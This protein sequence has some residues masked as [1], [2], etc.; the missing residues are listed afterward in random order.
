MKLYFRKITIL[1][2]TL[3][4][5]ETTFAG[6]QNDS[7]QIR[8]DKL[9]LIQNIDSLLN[10]R[11]ELIKYVE[12]SD[13][14]LFLELANKNLELAKKENI[15]WSQI[16]TYMEL[17][18]SFI[19][20]G[21]YGVALNYLNQALKL[22]QN[23]EYR[24]YVGWVT[25]SIGNCYEAMSSFKRA[26]EFF[27]LSMKVFIETEAT[28]GI[29]LAAT[30]IGNIYIVLRDFTNARKY[31]DKGFEERVK[32]K[33]PIELGYVR[34]SLA[35][36][37]MTTG[38]FVL[39]KESLHKLIQNL[40]D[41]V[42]SRDSGINVILAKD[43][44]GEAL[45]LLSEC[46]DS[47]GLVRLKYEHLFRA[48][49]LFHEMDD[50]LN[51]STVFNI[52]GRNYLIDHQFEEA[53]IY[54]DSARQTARDKLILIQQAVSD[55][56][57]S[58]IYVELKD[59][60]QALKYH[61]EYMQINDSMYNQSV[62][63]AI[64]NVDVFVET[65]TKEKNNQILVLEVAHEKKIRSIILIYLG[66][67]AFLLM[68]VITYVFNRYRKGKQVN[69][70][71]VVKNKQIQDQ[72]KRL[73][74]LNQ[75][76]HTLVKSKDKFHA[77][78]AHDL[79]NPVGS[80]Y[81][82]TDLLST[83]YDSFSDSEKKE[84]IGMLAETSKKTL[85]LLD[86]LLTWS[87]IQ[88]GHLKVN[89]THFEIAREVDEIIKSQIHFA[90][91]KSIA[92]NVE[93]NGEI[94]VF[95]DRE[96]ISTVVRNLFS[97]AIKYTS[98]GKNIVVGIKLKDRFVEIW[99]QDEG[100][101]IP[102]EKLNELFLIDSEFQRPGTNEE[103]GTGLGLQLSYEFVKLHDGYFD[104]KSEEFKGSRFAFFIPVKK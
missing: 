75:E 52:I 20:R 18:E 31:L 68:L 95:A 41:S 11:L 17:G 73:E 63:D 103:S 42:I 86:N 58:A 35:Q 45:Y 101:G 96:M 100:I 66:L 53:I 82:I 7:I 88:G 56:L 28:D 32:L 49:E 99:V 27:E 60:K 65:V 91:V 1:L 9:G 34:V 37:N 72:T 26:I 46:E 98:E 70:K 62:A 15:N 3:F 13:Y 97:N 10:A 5:I 8:I 81:S 33:D 77:I 69:N 67:F 14:A 74:E 80:V 64:S 19:N 94:E 23:D 90:E 12:S 55:V 57:L 78:I 61:K 51:L 44:I 16:D 48:V 38:D 40:N 54:A 43:V 83:S 25:L 47:L 21:N 22:A 89:K 87:R 24:P 85:N 29:A 4:C 93:H 59:Y 102:T 36:L 2:V 50:G 104:V 92:V 76:L 39:A 79:K 84:L 71:L 6:E 30:N